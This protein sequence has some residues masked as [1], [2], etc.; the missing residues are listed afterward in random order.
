MAQ[1]VR[2]RAEAVGVNYSAVMKGTGV[3]SSAMANYWTGKRPWPTEQLATLAD[4]LSTS[5]DELMGRQG[6]AH[7]IDADDAEFVNV[8]EYSL[9]EIDELGKLAPIS[10]TLMRR[11]WLYSS[12]GEASGIWIAQA[13][14]RHEGL[15]IDA[16]AMLFCKD[17]RLG[18]RMIHGAYYLFRVNGGVVLA[19]FALREDGSSEHTVLAR[20]IGPDDD[21]YQVVARVIGQLARPI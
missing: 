18:E 1:R 4:L 20:D 6:P 10:T 21:Q 15:T 13:P 8:P 9:F 19:R 2:D 17:F 5:V 3:S 12:L 16:G 11:D 14:A 7:L